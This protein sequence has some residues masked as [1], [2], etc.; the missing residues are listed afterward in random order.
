MRSYSPSPLM[1]LFFIFLRLPYAGGRAA[2]SGFKCDY[3]RIF[4]YKCKYLL[5]AAVIGRQVR[6]RGG[7]GLDMA[8][9]GSQQEAGDRGGGK[10]LLPSF[11]SFFLFPRSLAP[12]FHMRGGREA[13][14]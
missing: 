9:T 6:N 14:I 2:I 13:E 4:A 12:A 1:L 5:P 10:A 8:E 11:L 7:I 3:L